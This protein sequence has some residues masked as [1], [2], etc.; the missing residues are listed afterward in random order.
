MTSQTA[1]TYRF[2][3]DD[4]CAMFD[5]GIL[6]DET[7]VELVDGAVVEMSPRSARHSGVVAWLTEQFITTVAGELHVRVHDILL[8]PDGGFVRPVSW[9]SSR[10]LA[11]AGPTERG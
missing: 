9:S 5:A 3:V 6:D 2:S 8:T 4:V 1:T 7:R 10:C 11:I